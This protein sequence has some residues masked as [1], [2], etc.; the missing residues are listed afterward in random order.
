LAD[1][2]RWIA[3]KEAVFSGVAALFAVVGV[4]VS[5]VLV[6]VRRLRMGGAG[7]D[8]A[9]SIEHAGTTHTPGKA[10]VRRL[11]LHDF[12][13]PAPDPIHYAGPEN[14]R[15]A[16]ISRGEVRH[17]GDLP[18]VIVPGIVSH[19]HIAANLPALRDTFTA[20]SSMSRVVHFDKRGQ[21]LSDPYPQAP[22]LQERSEEIRLVMDD[23]GIERALLFGFSEG[24]PVTVQFAHEHPQRCAGLVLAGTTASWLRTED[25]PIGLSE[26]ALD[27]LPRIWGTPAARDLFFPSLSRDLVDDHTFD[28][29]Q[30]LFA[31]RSYISQLSR[32]LKTVDVRPL[33]PTL[34]LPVL[35]LHFTGDLAV[36]MRL[37]RALAEG[38]PGARFLAVGGTD[39]ADFAHSPEAIEAIREFHS[40]LQ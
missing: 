30:M 14:G 19:L 38:I 3:D 9:A 17:E 28:K 37:G 21:G 13:H 29:V 22:T 24:G 11:S 34:Q 1:I 5:A 2:G 27:A 23:A 31:S 16:Y 35:V 39:H 25:F 33:L 6:L 40:S 7:S 32:F 36:P 10:P 15:V 12:S 8:E 18:M 26:N 20:L 4:C